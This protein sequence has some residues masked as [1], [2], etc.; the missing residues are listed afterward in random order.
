MANL[1]HNS[2]SNILYNLAKGLG[3]PRTDGSDSRFHV[4][5]MPIGLIEYTAKLFSFYYNLQSVSTHIVNLYSYT[6]GN[7]CRFHVHKIIV[8]PCIAI[9][10]RSEY[11]PAL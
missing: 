10:V 5:R 1:R 8:C 11:I 6:D 7:F 9:L 3:T 4:K 2:C